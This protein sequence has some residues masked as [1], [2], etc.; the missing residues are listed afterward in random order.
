M[1][2]FLSDLLSELLG[3]HLLHL[4]NASLRLAAQNATTPM[5]TNLLGT[6]IEVVP[7]RLDDFAK[8]ALVLGMGGGQ[9]HGGASLTTNDLTQASLTLDDAVGNIHF[10]AKRRKM[11]DEFD[12]IDVVRDDDQLRL[13]LFHEGCDRVEAGPDD[14]L[15]LGGRRVF[16][17]DL[18]LGLGKEARLLRLFA[19]RTILVQQ[20]DHLRGGRTVQRHGELVDGR[21]NLKT[22][23]ENGLLALKDHVFGPADETSQIPLGLDVLT[24]AE[25]LWTLLEQ[26]VYRLLGHRLGRHWHRRRSDLFALPFAR[27]LLRLGTFGDFTNHFEI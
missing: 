5:T 25:V 19:L 10:P 2:K 26:R 24:N 15:S 23:E 22:L 12:G 6:V 21:R 17:V 11:H 8:G 4:G 18:L 27:G 7:D 3:L 13:L 1:V 16:A 14:G 20:L 9:T